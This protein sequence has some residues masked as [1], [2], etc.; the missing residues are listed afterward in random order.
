MTR[1]RPPRLRRTW[2]F[3]PGAERATL[4]EAAASGADV[5]IQELEDFCPPE[6]RAEARG[7]APELYDRWRGRGAVAA[8]RINPLEG[9]GRAD[10]AE[11]M[12]GRPD[13]VLMSKVAAPDQVRALE[14]AVAEAEARLGIAP[15]ATELVPNIET[16]AGLVRTLEI[17]RASPRVTACLIASEDMVA[18]LGTERSRDGEELAYVR[19][20]FL[21]ECVAA[22]I[23]AVD[24]PYTFADEA[25]AAADTER[26]R[27]LGYVAKSVVAPAHV[28]AV[29]HGLTP[30]AEAVARAHR[31]AASFEAARAAGRDRAELDGHLVEV[32]AYAAARRL[33]ARAEEFASYAATGGE[34]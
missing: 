12:R 32:P 28:A 21:V 18:D 13:V 29:N 2:L 8:V 14:A 7:L 31:L 22:G 3:L 20:R 33:I 4:I 17:A 10:L 26:A 30:A 9:D 25:G 1:R 11:V 23:V 19:A 16:A 34:R 24:C 15:G 6:R 5:L 27:R